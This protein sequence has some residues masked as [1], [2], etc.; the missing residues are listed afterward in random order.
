[1]E[2]TWKNQY[3][4]EQI[5]ALQSRYNQFPDEV[6]EVEK[7]WPE[8]FKKFEAAL[9]DG[10]DPASGEVQALAE[11]AQRFIDLFTGKDKAIEANLDKASEQNKGSALQTWGVSAEVFEYASK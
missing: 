6:K 9:N 8:L 10:L 3:T 5:K 2:N 1:M 11:K 7:A 4:P